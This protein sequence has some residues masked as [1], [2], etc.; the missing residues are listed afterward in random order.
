MIDPTG[1][2]GTIRFNTLQPPFDDPAIRRA[3]LGAFNQSDF[4]AAIVGND[5]ALQRDHVGYFCPI[6]PM[7]SDAGLEALTPVPPRRRRARRLSRP[8][9]RGRR[10]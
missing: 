4:M 9:T 3:L 2:I 6:S 7:A 10:P 1:V 5:K 8:A